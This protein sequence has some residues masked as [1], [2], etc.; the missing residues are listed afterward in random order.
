[1]TDFNPM[2][3]MPNGGM[4]PFRLIEQ[5]LPQHA[6]NR[7]RGMYGV[8]G[9]VSILLGA[10]L[11]FWPGRT[12]AVAAVVLGIYLLISG[13]VRI[14][15][16]IVELGLPGGWRVLGVLFGALMVV[17][18]VIIVRNTSLSAT[19]LTM[20][21]TMT[22]GIGWLLEGIMTLFECW[23]VPSSAWAVIYALLSIVAGFVAL[24]NPFTSTVW[25]LMFVAIAL[26]V[27][28]IMA[29][30]RAIRFGK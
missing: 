21:F 23:N 18:G 29:V 6:K 13:M 26:I 25:L 7:I 24:F 12:L 16:A 9:I 15:T 28:G 3:N 10:A 22:V 20:L 5:T 17:G 14:V 11:L 4:D 1:M 27:I 8:I 2:N 30:I 19:M